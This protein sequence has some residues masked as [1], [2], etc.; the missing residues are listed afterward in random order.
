MNA[1]PLHDEGVSLFDRVLDGAGRAFSQLGVRACTIE[2]I[3]R[4]A[5]VSR[6]TVYRHVGP[7]AEVFRQLAL[8]NTRS[9]YAK[10]EERWREANEL[11]DIVRA[12]F[13]QAQEHYTG[14]A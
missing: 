7:K 5:G 2:Q 13:L 9:Y 3:A 10:L 4:E 11:S 12:A 14:N 6:I 8:R 1:E